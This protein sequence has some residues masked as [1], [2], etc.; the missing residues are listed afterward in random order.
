MTEKKTRAEMMAE[1]YGKKLENLEPK[2]PKARKHVASDE[3]TPEQKERLEKAKA[4]LRD[5]I[6]LIK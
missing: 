2:N 4:K 5:F 1:Q 3:Q 6:D